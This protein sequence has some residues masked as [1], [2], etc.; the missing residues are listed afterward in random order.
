MKF[1]AEIT[2][3]H[4]KMETACTLPEMLTAITVIIHEAWEHLPDN[5]TKALFREGFEQA[6]K[7]GLPFLSDEER[8]DL[9]KRQKDK[10]DELQKKSDDLDG[11][12]KE[13]FNGLKGL[14]L[15]D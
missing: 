3:E 14:L 1:L 8:K 12:L 4:T 6:M 15:D 9:A 7:D 11:K 13:L 10:L 5:G 2:D